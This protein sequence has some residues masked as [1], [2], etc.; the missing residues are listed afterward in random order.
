MIFIVAATAS[1]FFFGLF[2]PKC[3]WFIYNVIYIQS[4]FWFFW[5]IIIPSIHVVGHDV[6]IFLIPNHFLEI[7]HYMATS[8]FELAMPASVSTKKMSLNRKW[9]WN[10]KKLTWQWP[11]PACPNSPSSS[12]HSVARPALLLLLSI[13]ALSYK[14]VGSRCW[15]KA[16]WSL[17]MS[18]LKLSAQIMCWQI[19][20]CHVYHCHV[21]HDTSLCLLNNV[22]L[23]YFLCIQFYY[24]VLKCTCHYLQIITTM[25]VWLNIISKLMLCC[26]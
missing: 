4:N 21:A 9:M 24:G 8:S 7:S 5:I 2:I 6:G 18:Q 17:W 1:F 20:N 22:S 23:S 13:Q 11:P 19:S 26:S 25:L 3:F 15:P 16:L 14:A 12:S 10:Y